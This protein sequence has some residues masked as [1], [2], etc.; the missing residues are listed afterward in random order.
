MNNLKL[1]NKPK[2]YSEIINTTLRPMTV[3]IHIHVHAHTQT[4]T[5]TGK[6]QPTTYFKKMATFQSFQLTGENFS[7]YKMTHLKFIS[8]ISHPYHLDFSSPNLGFLEYDLGHIK[9][10]HFK[11][12]Q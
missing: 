5:H 1:E 12:K 2:L 9:T 3:S 8:L 6:K 11:E 4:H 10:H 7:K